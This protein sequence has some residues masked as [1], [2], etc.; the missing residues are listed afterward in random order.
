MTKAVLE[1][2]DRV[3]ATSRHPEELD[4]LV[5]EYPD[6]I[7]IVELDVTRSEDIAK[8]VETAISTFDGIDVLVNNAGFGTLGTVEEVAEDKIRYQF[9][10]NYFG[11]LNLTRAFLSH[12]RQ[13]RSGNYCRTRGI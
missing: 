4:D 1:K 13:K 9:E 11:T 6:T 3:I 5:K 10:V 2:G 8:A 7:K 12:F